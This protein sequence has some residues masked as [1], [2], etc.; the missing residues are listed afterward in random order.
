MVFIFNQI[1]SIVNVFQGQDLIASV[2]LEVALKTYRAWIE[3]GD[4]CYWNG[5]AA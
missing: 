5:D 1:D 4:E 3:D 2:P